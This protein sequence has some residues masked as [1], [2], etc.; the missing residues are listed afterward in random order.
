LVD[1]ESDK[2]RY[3]RA[4]DVWTFS[5]VL[6]LLN[7]E[8]PDSSRKPPTSLNTVLLE[9]PIET[10]HDLGDGEVLIEHTTEC[11]VYQPIPFDVGLVQ[12]IGDAVAAGSLTPLSSS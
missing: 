5:E 6:F 12:L 8:W 7:G 2:A 10:I 4:C 9:S 1:Y 11:N 3:W